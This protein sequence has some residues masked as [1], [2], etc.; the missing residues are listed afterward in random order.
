MGI[1]DSSLP[2]TNLNDFMKN[3]SYNGYKKSDIDRR[4]TF[5]NRFTSGP[6]ETPDEIK[7]A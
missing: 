7:N 5:D 3:F 4:G 1:Y 6:I 2:K